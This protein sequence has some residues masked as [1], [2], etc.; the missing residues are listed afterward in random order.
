[1]PT[2]PPFTHGMMKRTAI[3]RRRPLNQSYPTALDALHAPWG[4]TTI[5]NQLAHPCER[6]LPTILNLDD[7]TTVS[8]GLGM[9]K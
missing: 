4:L 7:S 1:M 3:R 8:R 2:H 9:N 6:Q 5:C